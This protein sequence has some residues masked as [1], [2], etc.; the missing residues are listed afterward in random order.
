MF[1]KKIIFLSNTA[2]PY[3]VENC[4][5]LNEKTD[6]TY[7]FVFYLQQEINRP[8][9]WESVPFNPINIH[10]LKKPFHL[11]KNLYI[12]FDVIHKLK[13]IDPDIVVISGY[14]LLT[15]I[16]AAI[17]AKLNNKKTI[18]FL[19]RFLPSSNLKRFIKASILKLLSILFDKFIVVGNDAYKEYFYLKN[20]K[21][22]H[23]LINLDRYNVPE[24]QYFHNQKVNFLYSGRFSKNQNTH[25]IVEAFLELCQKYDNIKLTLS[26]YGEELEQIQ[27]KIYKSNFSASVEIDNSYDSWFKLPTLYQKADILLAPL[28]HSGW[29]FV[30]EEAMASSLAIISTYETTAAAEYIIDNYNGFIINS[31]KENIKQ[32]MER[33]ILERELVRLHGNRNLEIK[34]NVSYDYMIKKFNHNIVTE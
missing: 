15:G 26:G 22:V 30:I 27:E 2:S 31:S 13:E 33:Y 8:K 17:W 34:Q 28:N 24:K 5:Y 25:T 29:G 32:A 23:Y 7:H 3:Q 14:T 6:N 1:N 16:Y 12:N 18:L 19:E 4:K 20:K 9:Y 21:N 11:T 10:I